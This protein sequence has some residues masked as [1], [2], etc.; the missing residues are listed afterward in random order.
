MKVRASVK[1]E[2]QTVRSFEEKVRFTLS[3][4]KTQSLNSVKDKIWHVLQ[5]TIYQRISEELLP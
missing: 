3:I 2:Q 4:R 1:N 5:E